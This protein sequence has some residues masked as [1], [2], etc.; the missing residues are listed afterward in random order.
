[1]DFE[2]SPPVYEGDDVLNNVD[3]S[4]IVESEKMKRGIGGKMDFQMKTPII[5]FSGPA[6]HF[7]DD[8]KAIQ[9]DF[10]NFMPYESYSVS[11]YISL[12]RQK[13][14]ISYPK[15]EFTDGAFTSP[16]N[17]Y[18]PYFNRFSVA[19]PIQYQTYDP[20]FDPHK[21]DVRKAHIKSVTIN[22]P[23]HPGDVQTTIYGFNKGHSKKVFPN[24]LNSYA[25][26]FTGYP[27]HPKRKFPFLPERFKNDQNLFTQN[28]IRKLK[29]ATPVRG[30]L[31]LKKVI[32]L[33]FGETV[34]G[35]PIPATPILPEFYK[36]SI[37]TDIKLANLKAVKRQPVP[38]NV[39]TNIK[40][41]KKFK[42]APL[43]HHSAVTEGLLP[44][45]VN[46]VEGVVNAPINVN[47]KREINDIY[48]SLDYNGNAVGHH[49]IT[50]GYE[51]KNEAFDNAF[52]QLFKEE[53]L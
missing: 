22:Q 44:S 25:P 29:P 35:V 26:A 6:F 40:K 5:K 41:F 13:G 31:G 47:F 48:K 14:E 4:D 7:S 43:M 45:P 11:P 46:T 27:L 50:T 19:K 18:R 34:P 21:T 30:K 53:I 8:F 10:Y 38:S 52:D 24:S 32:E 3:F 36:S 1:M 28:Y 12:F 33:P 2:I 20:S 9:N 49:Y 51:N 16:F 15:F 39:L 23:R 37:Q 42:N 17:P